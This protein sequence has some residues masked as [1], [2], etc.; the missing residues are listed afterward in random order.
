MTIGVPLTSEQ[1][2]DSEIKFLNNKIIVRLLLLKNETAICSSV[3]QRQDCSVSEQCAAAA[4][5]ASEILGSINE[6]MTSRDQEATTPLCPALVQPDLEHRVKF[7]FTNLLCKECMG[8]L[9]EL[10][11]FSLEKGRHGGDFTIMFHHL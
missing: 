8:R 10:C 1:S 9:R 7:Y 11:L 3:T 4:K 2:L 6:C 5:H